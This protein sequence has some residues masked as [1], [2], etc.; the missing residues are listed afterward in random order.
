MKQTPSAD[1]MIARP[2]PYL[3]LLLALLAIA[4]MALAVIIGTIG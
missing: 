3:T 4:A 1:P 2:S